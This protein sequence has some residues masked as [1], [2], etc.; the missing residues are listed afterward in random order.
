MFREGYLERI[1]RNMSFPA[2]EQEDHSCDCGETCDCT[3]E[4]NCG[5]GMNNS[6]NHQ[7]H[8][9]R[10]YGFSVTIGQDGIPRVQE[11]GNVPSPITG[12]PLRS[13][14]SDNKI[15]IELIDFESGGKVIAEMPGVEKDDFK[16]TTKE[17]I[18]FIKAKNNNH[19]YSE[20]VKLPQNVNY[21]SIKATYKNGV[22]EV[23]FDYDKGFNAET[24]KV[25]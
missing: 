7:E 25:E 14:S 23:K 17:H 9:E 1:L 13:K 20:E 10:F 2:F 11:Y 3:P 16:I 4:K 19:A 21:K 24:I 5:C 15:H 8:Q 18:L 22:L 6:D 12:R